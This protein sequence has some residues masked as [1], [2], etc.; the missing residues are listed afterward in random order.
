MLLYRYFTAARGIDLLQSLKLYFT[1]PTYFND[2]HEFSPFV[3]KTFSREEYSR[4]FLTENYLR[5]VWESWVQK[6]RTALTFEQ[7]T[8]AAAS[9]DKVFK[10]VTNRV[11]WAC[12]G[13]QKQFKRVMSEHTGVCC[14]SET[15][16]SNLMWAHY[17]DAH[18]GVCIGME[19]DHSDIRLAHI[20]QVRYRDQKVRI[21]PW[22]LKL[23][24]SERND[25]Y[26]DIAASKGTEW[27]YEKEHRLIANL[28]ECQRLEAGDR[29]D[30][31]QVLGPRDIKTIAVGF[32]CTADSEVSRAV[33]PHKQIWEMLKCTQEPESFLLRLTT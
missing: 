19:L 23:S 29:T 25:Y 9:D 28:E 18:R 4:Y 20:V 33:Q 17:A 13:L 2:I 5:P 15:P 22:F 26:K 1:P 31:F 10:E 3:E 11:A 12:T 24:E 27:S 16:T 21:P 7:F 32:Q 6:G 8:L 14:L 30:F